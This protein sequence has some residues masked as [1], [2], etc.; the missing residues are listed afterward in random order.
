MSAIRSA[1]LIFSALA[2]ST[3]GFSIL[4]VCGPSA[5]PSQRGSTWKCRW[6]TTCP[7]A[8]SLNCV[9]VMPSAL[10]AFITALATFCAVFMQAASCVGLASS[11]LRAGVFGITSVCPWQRGMMSMIASVSASSYTFCDGSSPRRIFANT[12]LVS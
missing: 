3:S 7:P 10:K 2:A 5:M 11:R 8:G 9:S 4:A 6:N 12:L 1:A